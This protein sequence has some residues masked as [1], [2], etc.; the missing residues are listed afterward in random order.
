MEEEEEPTYAIHDLREPIE[1]IFEVTSCEGTYGPRSGIGFGMAVADACLSGSYLG[2]DSD[3]F[4][5][6]KRSGEQSFWSNRF[7]ETKGPPDCNGE[8]PDFNVGD[9][10]GFCYDPVTAKA[11]AFWNS[12]IISEFTFGRL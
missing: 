9:I 3:S 4:G 10:V 8:V 11:S 2:E 5:Y 7:G 6:C 12:R 1:L